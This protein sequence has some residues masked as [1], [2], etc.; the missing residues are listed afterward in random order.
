MSED[1]N[2]N[3]KTFEQLNDSVRNQV[4]A[5][6]LSTQYN[7][8]LKIEDI[9]RNTFRDIF[10]SNNT[11]RVE[12]NERLANEKHL[13]YDEEN[14]KNFLTKSKEA[15]I[16]YSTKERKIKEVEQYLNME[17]MFKDYNKENTKYFSLYDLNKRIKNN[18]VKLSELINDLMNAKYI[19]LSRYYYKETWE[20][21]KNEENL[22]KIF[23]F[24]NLILFDKLPEL[25]HID[26]N[27]NFRYS[28]ITL[29]DFESLNIKLKFFNEH[30]YYFPTGKTD[31]IL[32]YM[33][34][35]LKK[36]LAQN[37]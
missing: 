13:I 31:K 23:E 35:Q 7:A 36:R 37:D 8:E 33:V 25:K 12:F 11:F 14:I 21:Y 28:P 3:I 27:P 15:V 10:Y 17:K 20:N 1:K 30:Y 5:V 6:G 29:N 24:F 34:E 32:M 16:E 18:E 4:K 22:I 2:N 19:I 9:K 26:N